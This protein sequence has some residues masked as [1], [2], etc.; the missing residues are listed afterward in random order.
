MYV[1]GKDGRPA[2]SVSLWS[3]QKL[4]SHLNGSLVPVSLQLIFLTLSTLLHRRG[5]KR[6]GCQNKPL[7]WVMCETTTPSS[8]LSSPS[9]SSSSSC[10]KDT[11][12]HPLLWRRLTCWWT[13]S[14]SET[15]LNIKEQPHIHGHTLVVTPAGD[16]TGF[17]WPLDDVA[18]YAANRCCL[19]TLF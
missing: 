6:A 18:I 10:P 5:S 3:I 15:S 19:Q 9:S 2:G 1:G 13:S 14:F 16:P 17:H 8:L 7:F 11:I 4:L 12:N